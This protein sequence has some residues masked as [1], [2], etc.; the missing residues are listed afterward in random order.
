M[1]HCTVPLCTD[2]SRKTKGTDISYYKLAHYYSIPIV[3]APLGTSRTTDH[4]NVKMSVNDHSEIKSGSSKRFVR[5]FTR[6]AC[7]AFGRW[8]S[9]HNW[10]TGNEQS[11]TE[12]AT[13]LT[14]TLC[15]AIDSFFPLKVVDIHNTDKLWMTPALKRL[16]IERQQAFHSCDRPA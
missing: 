7:D 8:C 3:T 4:C 2:G 14:T 13:S 6:S 10:F 5:R 11:A 16:I 9:S 1:P 12:L 15:S